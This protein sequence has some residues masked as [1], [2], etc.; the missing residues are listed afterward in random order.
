MVDATRSELEE[1]RQLLARVTAERDSL[2]GERDGIAAERDALAGRHKALI[3]E[4][5]DI[6]LLDHVGEHL[7]GRRTGRAA[8]AGEKFNHR[9]WMLDILLRIGGIGEC[10][11]QQGRRQPEDVRAQRNVPNT[12]PGALATPRIF[13]V[14]AP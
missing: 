8:L 4:R 1:L 10:K 9:A 3:G 13:D 12:S 6:A 11:N 7:V 2:S 14:P 5:D